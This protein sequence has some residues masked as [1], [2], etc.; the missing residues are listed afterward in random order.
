MTRGARSGS[1]ADCQAVN[2]QGGLTDADRHTLT[3]F[4]AGAD[5]GVQF[6][7]VA[8]HGHAHQHIGAVADQRR[9]P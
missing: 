4:A 7:I 3:F 9:A 8:D 1:A 2:A 5:T 6:Q